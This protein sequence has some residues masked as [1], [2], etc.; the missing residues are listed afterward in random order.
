LITAYAGD[1]AYVRR[2]IIAGNDATAYD[3]WQAGN[4]GAVTDEV[5]SGYEVFKKGE[6]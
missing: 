2:T 6:V 3:R 1:C 4:Q 5:K